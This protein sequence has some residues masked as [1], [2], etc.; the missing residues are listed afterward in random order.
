VTAA[1]LERPLTLLT[2]L[3]TDFPARSLLQYLITT[4]HRDKI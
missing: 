2:V 4:G 3:D 1:A